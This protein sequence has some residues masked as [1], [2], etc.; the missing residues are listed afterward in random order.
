MLFGTLLALHAEEAPPPLIDIDGTILVQFVLFLTM[1]AILS[2]VLFRP[3][4]KMREQRHQGIEGAKDAA[5]AMDARAHAIVADYDARLSRAKQRGNEE[6]ATLRQEG[7]A[8]ERQV[9]GKA[10]DQAQRALEEARK[11]VVDQA[12]TARATLGAESTALARKIAGKI[13]GR[14]LA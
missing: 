14:E 12:T 9:L 1:L 13:L 5:K 8:H 2:R 11:Q 3:Y 6:R 4:L 7:A 10:R